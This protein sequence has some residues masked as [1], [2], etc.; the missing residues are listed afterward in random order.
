MSEVTPGW[1]HVHIGFENDAVSLRGTNPW[2][3]KWRPLPC[4]AIIVAHPA[5]PQ[6]RHD[7]VV[8]E[9]DGPAGPIKFA[10]GEFSNG[11][12]GFYVPADTDTR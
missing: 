1:R 11:V 2:K 7:M 3:S 9:M 12:W 10:A 4:P 6:Q 5:Y 8:Y